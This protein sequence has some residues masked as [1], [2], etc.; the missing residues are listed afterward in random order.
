MSQCS[1]PVRKRVG[2]WT[3]PVGAPSRVP[4]NSGYCNPVSN[5]CWDVYRDDTAS[6]FDGNV[7]YG[8][9]GV[10]LGKVTVYA[11]IV[12]RGYQ[13][14]SNPVRWESTGAVK[15]LGMSGER[16]YW[17]PMN[18]KCAPVSPSTYKQHT[19]GRIN[20]DHIAVWPSGGY[21]ARE[22][23]VHVGAVVH[24]YDW[25]VF[26]YPGFWWLVVKGVHFRKTS[27]GYLYALASHLCDSPTIP[28]YTS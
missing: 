27:S 16:F 24:Q 28:G 6:D 13:S 25:T 5:F 26:D 10:F 21:K 1:L 14:V 11:Q 23:T 9:G 3:C 17:S 8:Y 18:T 19:F 22:T 12:L 15:G 2:A 7:D 4:A 20:A